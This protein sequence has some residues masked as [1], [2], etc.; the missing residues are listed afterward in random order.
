MLAEEPFIRAQSD[1]RIESEG[2]GCQDW[3]YQDGC[4]GSEERV[5]GM[6]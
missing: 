5:C 6:H 2:Q 4:D 1:T 3:S